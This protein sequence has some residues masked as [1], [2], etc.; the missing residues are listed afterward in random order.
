M[1]LSSRTFSYVQNATLGKEN[2]VLCVSQIALGESNQ[3]RKM[4]VTLEELTVFSNA[5]KSPLPSW[6]ADS[7]RRSWDVHVSSRLPS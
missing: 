7:C 4:D 1:L 6:A 5:V 3:L 2:A